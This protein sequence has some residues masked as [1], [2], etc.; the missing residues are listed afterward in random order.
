MGVARGGDDV[1]LSLIEHGLDG[2]R[3]SPDLTGQA[4]CCA[5]VRIADEQLADLI[6]GGQHRSVHLAD[7]ACPQQ[8]DPHR[9]SLPSIMPYLASAGCRTVPTAAAL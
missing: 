2:L 9:R 1:G 7:P 4:L 8:S 3:A 5:R 6:D